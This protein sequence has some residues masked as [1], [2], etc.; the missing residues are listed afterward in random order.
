MRI[1]RIRL[2]HFR[3]YSEL[4]LTLDA[5]TNLFY[6]DNA[7]GKTNIL[8]SMY[9]C[10]TTR[11]HRG[12]KDSQ[13]LMFGSDEAHIQMDVIRNEIPCRIDMHL[14]KS[15]AKGIAVNRVPVK[16]AGELI[17]ICSFIFFSP[18]DLGIIKN[19]PAVRRRFMDMELGQL[20]GMY[21]NDLY[22]YSKVLAQRNRLLKDI[23]WRKDL[24]DTLDVW[25]QQLCM[26]GKRIIEGRERFV[27][28]LEKKTVPIHEKLTGGKEKIKVLYEKNTSAAEMEEKV[29]SGRERDL[30]MGMTMTGPH[31]DDLMIMANGIDLRLFGSQGQQR[32]GA[33]SLK[34]AE[35]ELVKEMTSDAPV[36][37][38]DDVLSELDQG[39]QRYLLESIQNVQ[40]MITCTGKDDF[41]GNDF[42]LD[43]L[44]FVKD[45]TVK[46]EEV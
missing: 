15:R 19:G 27:E 46:V 35:I 36:L 30:Q 16:K 12:S 6:G 44:F 5:G 38:L 24:L 8:E 29:K 13:M 4:D 2:D 40:T 41:S 14:K 43:R 32:T 11:S 7:Q 17:G 20:S 10:G 34:L 28:K 3:N 31:R 45:G 1:E 25:D 23:A 37:F 42:K 21:L 33:L 26:Y 39:R 22:G 18:E 9:L